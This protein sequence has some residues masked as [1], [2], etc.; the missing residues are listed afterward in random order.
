MGYLPSLS[1]LL[2]IA[3][4]IQ[5]HSISGKIIASPSNQNLN[6][7]PTWSNNNFFS[8]QRWLSLDNKELNDV[9][10]W[11]G[12]GGTRRSSRQL[13]RSPGLRCPALV[14]S[15]DAFGSSGQTRN[16]SQFQSGLHFERKTGFGGERAFYV[17]SV[18]H[19]FTKNVCFNVLI[20]LVFGWFDLLFYF[21]CWCSF[22]NLYL[23]SMNCNVNWS[24]YVGRRI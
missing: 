16:S 13:G 19:C 10:R 3:E 21:D 1:I 18:S 5:N 23:F 7:W 4:F 2:F 11:S 15:A 22:F 17:V 6:E 12:G 24:N 9:Y 20:E 14:P 8:K